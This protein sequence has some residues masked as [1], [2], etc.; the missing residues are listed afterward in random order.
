MNA[1]C[2]PPPGCYLVAEVVRPSSLETSHAVPGT[3][4]KQLYFGEFI[5]DLRDLLNTKPADNEAAL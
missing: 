1:W 2:T 4:K 5:N 3:V